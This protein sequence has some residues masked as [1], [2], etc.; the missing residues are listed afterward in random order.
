MTN[1]ENFYHK[2]KLLSLEYDDIIKLDEEY[3]KI[4]LE[5]CISDL[6]L[7]KSDFENNGDNFFDENDEKQLKNIN[8]SFYCIQ[9][10]R[11]LAIFLH[12]DKNK[13]SEED[14]IKLSKV[15]EKDDFITLFILSYENNIKIHLSEQEILNL[16]IYIYL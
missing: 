7:Q 10:Y 12:P 4:F 13:N 6:N 11:K 1:S 8:H 15:Y 5:E 2:L 9:L 3:M 16:L 14:F